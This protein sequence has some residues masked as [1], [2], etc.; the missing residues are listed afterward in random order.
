MT[1]HSGT[2]EVTQAEVVEFA[3]R[4]DPQLFHLDD[5]QARGTF[6]DGLAAS[7]LTSRSSGRAL[8]DRETCCIS[9]SRLTRSLRRAHAQIAPLSFS[10]MTRSTSTERS[11]SGVRGVSS[12]GSD[13]SPP[14]RD[15]SDGHRFGPHGS[16]SL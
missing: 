3:S 6:F 15:Q 5:E 11:G 10:P 7:G 1:F 13:R 8:H 2:Y 9:R 16:V 4:Y 14:Q 12:P